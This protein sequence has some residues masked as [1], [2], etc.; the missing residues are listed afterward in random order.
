MPGLLASLIRHEPVEIGES[1]AARGFELGQDR[2]I[3]D[4]QAPRPFLSRRDRR[5]W[6]GST[7]RSSAWVRGRSCSSSLY[8]NVRALA[9]YR[10]PFT[11]LKEGHRAR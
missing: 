10:P 6:L 9:L 1:S 3:R 5:P 8:L 11:P 2:L 4:R 7:L